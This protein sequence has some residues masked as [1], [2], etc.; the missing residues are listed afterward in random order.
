MS[1]QISKNITE[2]TNIIKYHW[3]QHHFDYISGENNAI[4]VAAPP[5]CNNYDQFY[6]ELLGPYDYCVDGV[7]KNTVFNQNK[8]EVTEMLRIRINGNHPPRKWGF[9]LFIL[10]LTVLSAILFNLFNETMQ[11]TVDEYFRFNE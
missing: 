3:T 9:S 8:N 7:D 5:Q 4:N 6:A 2:L 10:L 11:S 1:D